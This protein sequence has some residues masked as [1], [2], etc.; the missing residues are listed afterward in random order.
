MKFQ[1]FFLTFQLLK[2]KLYLQGRRDSLCGNL[3]GVLV[4]PVS[5]FSKCDSHTRSVSITRKVMGKGDS[6]GDDLSRWYP[7]KTPTLPSFPEHCVPCLFCPLWHCVFLYILDFF[8]MLQAS[9]PA[10]SCDCLP[11]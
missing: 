8:F 9:K 1:L 7:E 6:N 4:S 5:F 3:L 11:F 2:T 10:L